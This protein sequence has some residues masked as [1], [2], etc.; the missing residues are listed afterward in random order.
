MHDL[1]SRIKSAEEI[2]EALSN[3]LSEGLISLQEKEE[4]N[5]NSI[6][7]FQNP[8]FAKF[9]DGTFLTK[10]EQEIILPDGTVIRPDKIIIDGET[11]TVVDFKTGKEDEKH[12]HQLKKYT[13]ALIQMGFKKTEAFIVYTESNTVKSLQ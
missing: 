9:F 2:Y 13:S 7:L 1:L 5:K 12:S 4:L 10:N 11:A 6:T 3:M 8:D